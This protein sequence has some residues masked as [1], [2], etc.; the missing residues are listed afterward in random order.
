MKKSFVK[1]SISLE[2]RNHSFV[3]QIFKTGEYNSLSATIN[4]LINKERLRET[5]RKDIQ[6]D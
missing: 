2:K 4:S 3:E 5:R 1:L 6:K